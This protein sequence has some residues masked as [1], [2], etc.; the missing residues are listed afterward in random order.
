MTIDV[1]K[2]RHKP[3]RLAVLVSGGG[4]TVANLAEKIASGELEAELAVAICS[5]PPSCERLLARD[6]GVPIHLV[7]R[8][9]Y[10]DTAAFSDAVFKIIR[11]ADVDLV[12]LAGFLC[13]L[14]IPDDFA[15]RVLNIH[16]ALLPAFGGKGMYGHHV[17]EAVLK[18]GCKVSGCTVHFADQTYDTGPILVQRACPVLPD[19]TP[20]TLAARVFAEECLAYPQAIR[21]LTSDNVDLQK[22]IRP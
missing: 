6:L 5:N 20:D 12:C 10:A 22:L 11:D 13:L 1:P 17:H 16:P 2:P 4:T 7:A 3:A 9:A 19:D 18:H 14:T 21:L 15:W 8:K